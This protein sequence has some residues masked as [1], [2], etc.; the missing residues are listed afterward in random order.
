[1]WHNSAPNPQAG[2]RTEKTQE[3]PMTMAEKITMENGTLKVPDNPV[4]P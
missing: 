3:R 4:I 1:V 2:S